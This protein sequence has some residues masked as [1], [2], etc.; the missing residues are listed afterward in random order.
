MYDCRFSLR[1][2]EALRLWNF[3]DLFVTNTGSVIDERRQR[4][5]HWLDARHF[6]SIYPR[7]CNTEEPEICLSHSFLSLLFVTGSQENKLLLFSPILFPNKQ[8]FLQ[9]LPSWTAQRSSLLPAC[10]ASWCGSTHHCNYCLTVLF[11][12]FAWCNAAE[13][14]QTKKILSGEH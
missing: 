6:T 4:P 11:P 1:H 12:L 7:R 5:I 2:K 8:T 10:G 3:N 14:R 9:N 13:I